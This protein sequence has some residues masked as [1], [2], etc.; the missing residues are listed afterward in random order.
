MSRRVRIGIRDGYEGD[1]EVILA[2]WDRAIAWMV[3]RGQPGQWGTEPASSRESVREAVAR[4]VCGP[5][6]R[7]AEIDGE[8]VGAS[9][10]VDDPPAHVPPTVLR[11]TYLLFLIS[12][13]RHAGMGI[14]A[15]LV[16][17]AA[18]DA[19][20]AGSEVLRVD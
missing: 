7:I 18:S 13:R 19:R 14:G 12:D 17:R 16:R 5:G 3:E 20:N 2:L 4:W 8:P 9:V 6:V 1:S 11:E 15:E 10:T